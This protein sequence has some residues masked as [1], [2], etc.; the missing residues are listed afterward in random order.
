MF[1]LRTFSLLLLCSLFLQVSQAHDTKATSEL[2][3]EQTPP[4]EKFKLICGDWK[5]S[6]DFYMLLL[7]DILEATPEEDREMTKMT[8]GAVVNTQLVK[9]GISFKDDGTAIM[10][11]GNVGSE[12]SM[13]WALSDDG[14]SI[15]LS[16]G[17]GNGE[18]WNIVVLNKESLVLEAANATEDTDPFQA[19]LGFEP[20]N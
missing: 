1:Y 15:T 2:L 12:D 7:E 17:A 9:I 14:E 5:V 8:Y 18:T 11:N 20:A 10:R 6:A 3:T 16:D 19:Y 13:F 4:N